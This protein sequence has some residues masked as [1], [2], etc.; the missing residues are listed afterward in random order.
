MAHIWVIDGVYI[1]TYTYVDS[2]PM[3]EPT[4]H[5]ERFQVDGHHLGTPIKESYASDRGYPPECSP[6]D[7][8]PATYTLTS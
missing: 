4:S 7:H 3:V 6:D 8:T 2:V 1:N 5:H